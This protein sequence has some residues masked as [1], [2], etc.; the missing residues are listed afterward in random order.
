L[1]TII[2]KG[3]RYGTLFT[4]QHLWWTDAF[5]ATRA[6]SLSTWR[7]C[8]SLH[9]VQERDNHSFIHSFIHLYLSNDKTIK[10]QVNMQ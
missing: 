4:S 1:T 10:M 6:V 9:I 8:L 7:I 2:Q 5:A 3:A